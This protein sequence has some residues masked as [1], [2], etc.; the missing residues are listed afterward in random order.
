MGFY[1][2]YVLPRFLDMAMQQGPITK[3]RAKVVPRAE[4]R[5]L[6]IGIG[7][8]LNLPFYDRD[9]IDKL[10]GLDPSLE[11]QAM[12]RRRA[13]EA[14]ID[15]DFLGLSGEDIPLDA[16][17][18]DTVMVTY[19]LCTIPDVATA[20]GEMRRVLRKNGR[21][22]FAEHGRAPDHSVAR[23]QNRLN[24]TWRRMAGRLQHEPTGAR[25]PGSRGIRG[26]RSRST[27]SARPPHPDLQLL[28]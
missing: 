4:G 13:C 11:L 23:W 7:S 15:V 6:E 9:K 12:A 2:K 1:D 27:L 20:L 5:I 3:Q 18:V 14:G 17:S 24:N 10:W 22:V 28:G 26:L 21:L 8:G 19:T 16:E 25:A